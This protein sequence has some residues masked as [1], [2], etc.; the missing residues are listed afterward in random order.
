MPAG[1]AAEAGGVNWRKTPAACGMPRGVVE[2]WVGGLTCQNIGQR[3]ESST[4]RR[5]SQDWRTG[6][7]AATRAPGG[8]S[9][10]GCAPWIRTYHARARV[11]C[12]HTIGTCAN[13]ARPCTEPWSSRL[14]ATVNDWT[15]S[16]SR[17]GRALAWVHHHAGLSTEA[18][19]LRLMREDHAA[20]FILS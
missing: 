5:A 14:P 16:T 4:P 19:G 7:P 1:K 9:H 3:R 18:R 13:Q 15:Q 2:Y 10:I 17:S 11:C 8:Y 20:E 6:K 12:W